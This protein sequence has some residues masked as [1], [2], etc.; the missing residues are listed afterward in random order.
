MS[1]QKMLNKCSFCCYYWLS[2]TRLVLVN[3]NFK[4]FFILLD[5][6]S[7]CEFFS[8][9]LLSVR[10]DI[11]HNI[12]FSKNI[13]VPKPTT[14]KEEILNEHHVCLIPE[15]TL[16]HGNIGMTSFTTIIVKVANYKWIFSSHLYNPGD[17]YIKKYIYI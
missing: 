10:W 6:C 13:K 15:K 17:F 5:K 9:S 2:F 8:R 7:P 1:K 16:S 14:S 4:T 11:L 12:F 3:P